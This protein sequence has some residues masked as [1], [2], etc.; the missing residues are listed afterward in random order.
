MVLCHPVPWS[1][2]FHESSLS[3]RLSLN[4]ISCQKC[5]LNF[6][7][8][9]IYIPFFFLLLTLFPLTWIFLPLCLY[10][11][12]AQVS[13]NNLY[14][15]HIIHSFVHLFIHSL[16]HSFITEHMLL[17]HIKD[18]EQWLIE[19]RRWLLLLVI[20]IKV[21]IVCIVFPTSRLEMVSNPFSVIQN[22]RYE[23]GGILLIPIMIMIDPLERR[24]LFLP[25]RACLWG[26][27]QGSK[28]S[29]LV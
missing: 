11:S 7:L 10:G 15:S 22:V 6:P 21:V 19:N 13:F 24:K 28:P 26:S 17:I 9:V 20:L 8:C 2:A 5:L 29:M 16:I 18:S 23:K 14:K 25:D 4:S 1:E 12:R 3:L 27:S